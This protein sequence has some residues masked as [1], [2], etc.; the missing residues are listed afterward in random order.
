MTKNN[1][2]RAR[3]HARMRAQSLCSKQTFKPWLVGLTLFQLATWSHA[4]EQHGAHEHGV[5]QLNIVKEGASLAIALETPAANVLGFEHLPKTKEQKHKVAEA[6][7]VLNAPERLFELSVGAACRH[8]DTDIE[9]EV[10]AA[11]DHDHHKEHDHSH[12]DH[13]H[14]DHRDHHH[15]EDHHKEHDHSHDEQHHEEAHKDQHDDEHHHDHG[16]KGH[17][18]HDHHNLAGEETHS[19]ILVQYAYTCKNPSKLTTIDVLLFETFSGF[20]EIDAQVISSKGQ[21]AV[22]LTS[23]KKRIEL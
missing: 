11:V 2:R 6:Y 15:D 5:A 13:H 21:Q 8:T 4:F 16:H 22:E 3:T 17:H 12:D 23:S 14:D 19:D 9:G 7:E 20:E 1:F 10:L 18:E